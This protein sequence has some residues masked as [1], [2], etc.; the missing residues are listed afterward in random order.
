M[1]CFRAHQ[2]FELE[3]K[4]KDCRY[5]INHQESMNCTILAVEEGPKTLQEIGNI[6]GV[7]RMRICQLEKRILSKISSMI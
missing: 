6:F 1:K 5:W 7:T 4:N 3:C 2:E